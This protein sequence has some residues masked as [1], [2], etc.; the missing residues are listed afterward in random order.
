MNNALANPPNY[1]R[2]P[3]SRGGQNRVE[4]EGGY[5]GA[6]LI[7]GVS[8]I[9]GGIEAAG[10]QVFIDEFALQQVT[11]EINATRTGIKS[12]FA[13]PTASGDSLGKQI[14][15]V[16]DAELDGEQVIADLHF[17]QSA[18]STPSGDLATYTM[19]LGEE[20][21][22]SFGISIAFQHDQDAMDRFVES[23]S[24]DGQFQSPD[25]RNINNWPHVRIEKSGLHAADVVDNPAANS[26]LFHREG[27]IAKQSDSFVR[28]ALGH[29]NERPESQFG[30]DPDRARGFV[31]RFLD[32]YN[33]EIKE[34]VMPSTTVDESTT[35]TADATVDTP[36]P[37]SVETGPVEQPSTETVAEPVTEAS[38]RTEAARFR[39]AFGDQ[40]A[41]YFA[42]GLTFEQCK[43]REVAELRNENETLKQKL[44]AMSAGEDT[45]VSFDAGD[46]KTR[47]GFASKIRCK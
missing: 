40:G 22:Q 32:T 31:A 19:T 30:L 3:V 38:D 8:V 45:P 34:T 15:R 2:S 36:A 13:H 26:G 42:E 33:L 44:A 27:D 43:E 16:M 7:K 21:P 28:Y 37:T 35:L 11:D 23:H 4:R 41:I 6:G 46:Q 17:L 5:R 47:N 24:I 18:H 14:G 9:T 39:A 20:D 25:P 12:R 1:F 29:S 10:H